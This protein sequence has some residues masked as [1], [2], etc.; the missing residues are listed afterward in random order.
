[1]PVIKITKELNFIENEERFFIRV[2]GKFIAGFY[3]FERAEVVATQ[4]AA[5]GGKE[6]TDEI[7]IKEIIC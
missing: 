5:N 4:L 3:T 2:D 1:M 7:T 6:K